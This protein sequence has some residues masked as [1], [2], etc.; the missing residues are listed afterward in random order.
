MSPTFHVAASTSQGRLDCIS[1]GSTPLARVLHRWRGQ[2]RESAILEPGQSLIWCRRSTRLPDSQVPWGQLIPQLRGGRHLPSDQLQAGS[3]VRFHVE[4]RRCRGSPEAAV[5]VSGIPS[6]FHRP[7]AV[8]PTHVLPVQNGPPGRGGG[9]PGNGY[10]DPSAHSPHAIPSECRAALGSC[11]K[12]SPTK[13]PQRA[14]VA[15]RTRHDR[16]DD[17]PPRPVG[18]G[19]GSILPWLVGPSGL[20]QTVWRAGRRRRRRRTPGTSTPRKHDASA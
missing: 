6:R 5:G 20:H 9:F 18:S 7:G 3:S 8:R 11:V 15:V 16:A 17:S 14:S 13:D 1:L 12:P 10:T 2:V 19:A 4:H